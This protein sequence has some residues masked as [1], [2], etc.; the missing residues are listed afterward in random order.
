[1]SPIEIK[2]TG[3]CDTP[4][5]DN[6]AA[7]HYGLEEFYCLICDEQNQVVHERPRR[8]YQAFLDGG[9]TTNHLIRPEDRPK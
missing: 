5:C 3:A 1:M 4:D 7:V 9:D 6:T 2:I 8:E